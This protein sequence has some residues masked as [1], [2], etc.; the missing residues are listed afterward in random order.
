MADITCGVPQG[1]VLGPLL[2]LIYINDIHASS[3]VFSFTADDTNI[4]YKNTSLNQLLTITNNELKKLSV[5]FKANKLLL[6]I[7]KTNYMLFSNRKNIMNEAIN[8]KIDESIINRVR[9]CKFLGTVIDENLTWKPHIDLITS[10]ISKNIGI[11]FKVGK[12][13]TKEAMKT[14]YHTLVYP[15][16]HYCNIIW[17][18]NYPS[19]LTRIEIL[20]KRAVRTIAKIQYR[21]STFNFFKELKILKIK[22]INELEM[23]LFL[24]KL[25]NNQIPINLTGLFSVNSQIHS[26][27]TRN[28]DDC[29]LPRK[30]SR[31]GQYSLTYQGP[32]LWNSIEN[33]T[34]KTKS[35]LIIYLRK[36]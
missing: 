33:K 18:N 12:F 22:E 35:F 32:K 36:T 15:Y 10:K 23:S 1:S 28:A 24:F 25:Y 34:R 7:S 8:L 29:H 3:K 31:L 2:F 14:L 11:M 5:W 19:R 13:L 4:F 9:E 27:G 30:S 17:A 6:N 16:F 26:Y 21:Y 20:Q